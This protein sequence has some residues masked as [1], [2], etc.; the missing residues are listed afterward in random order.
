MLVPR[1]TH[2]NK[3]FRNK[4]IFT[5]KLQVTIAGIMAVKQPLQ[6]YNTLATELHPGASN[7]G[8][9]YAS[10]YFGNS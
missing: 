4:A 6:V 8:S 5:R 10:V 2:V 9:V 7:G 3:T 1:K